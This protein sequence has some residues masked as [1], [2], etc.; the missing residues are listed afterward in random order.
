MIVSPEV[1]K[2][3]QIHAPTTV[4]PAPRVE[5]T[6]RRGGEPIAMA[7]LAAPLAGDIAKASAD[8]AKDVT[9]QMFAALRVPMIQG[10]RVVTRHHKGKTIQDTHSYA[11]PAWFIVGASIAIPVGLWILGIG[12]KPTAPDGDGKQKLQIAER[13]RMVLPFGGGTT[14]SLF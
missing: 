1:V 11:I 6:F 8:Y 4:R 2:A 12:I 13:P 7:A 3:S 9:A 5:A 14:V 10:E